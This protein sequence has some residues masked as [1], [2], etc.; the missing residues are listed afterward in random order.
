M[1]KITKK[2]KRREELNNSETEVK[3]YKNLVFDD[4][5]N[6][7]SGRIKIF[8][9]KKKVA[10][11]KN[12]R[13]NN[14]N[15]NNA[16]KKKNEVKKKYKEKI[17]QRESILNDVQAPELNIKIKR[18][19]NKKRLAILVILIIAVSVY[20]VMSVYNLI[21]N[22]TDSVLVSEGRISQEETVDGYVIR[23]ETVIRGENYKNGMVEIKS[24]G[25]RV[26]SGDP[27]FRYYSTGEEDLKQKIADLDVKIQEAME[28]N[29]ENLFSTDTR[30]LDSQI[31][32]TL[33]EVTKTNDIQMIREYKRS[34]AENITRK[35]KIAG[36][37]SPT[38]SY[39]KKLIDERSGYENELNSGAEY[40]NATRSGI[41]S[42][43]ID[44]LEEVLTTND[45]SK[46]NKEFLQNLN[47]KTG[48]II[49]ASNE[50]G[51][52][53]N[54][55]ICYMACTSKSNEANNAEI[56]DTVKLAL[57]SLR[58][59]DA[60]IEYI[61]RESDNEVT[62]IF[63]FTEGIEEL[64]NYRKV[65][66][67]II[68]WDAS[69]FKVPNTCI[70]EENGLN[71]VIRTRA[72]YLDR[73]LVKVQKATDNYSIVTNYSTS[74]LEELDIGNSV[75]T[76]IILYDELLLKPSDEQKNQTT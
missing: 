13:K 11:K 44:G 55:F 67:D 4:N 16:D 18:K 45:F 75:S 62:I 57:P 47:L 31:E 5:I 48:Q 46:I 27:I 74:E 24:E 23:D 15:K 32:E 49:S 42:Y 43:R 59:V 26:A 64:L 58:E 21:K 66:V 76:S 17:E 10:N 52:I 34:I 25:S 60:K 8:N 61:T 53:V 38:G 37:L 7:E 50:G 68:W 2:T 29:N 54:N 40:I 63:S 39:L 33:D 20:I 19:V 12:T 14:A 70:F 71:Y 30:L 56:G 3:D 51:K 28:E 36:E 1:K 72:G 6:F 73:V 69:G 9:K 35:A 41:V 65:S 22:P